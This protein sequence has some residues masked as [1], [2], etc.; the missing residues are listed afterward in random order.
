MA[1]LGELD[2]HDAK[3]V[4]A[5]AK[6]DL[7][8]VFTGPI[9][10][11]DHPDTGTQGSDHTEY[12]RHLDLCCRFRIVAPDKNQL[13]ADGT[14]SF[15]RRLNGPNQHRLIAVGREPIGEFKAKTHILLHNHDTGSL[16]VLSTHHNSYLLSVPPQ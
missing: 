16:I 8:Q 5:L 6:P 3:M 1:D 11:R 12:F 7:C 2:R 10:D 13:R 15:D 4:N 14:E 9:R